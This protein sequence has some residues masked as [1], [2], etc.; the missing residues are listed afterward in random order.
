MSD[1]LVGEWIVIKFS[2][3]HHP[4]Q[5]HIKQFKNDVEEIFVTH[6]FRT[7]DN[8]CVLKS[9]HGLNFSIAHGGLPALKLPFKGLHSILFACGFLMHLVN[10]TERAFAQ[11]L[12][13]L[14][15]ICD[16]CPI[17]LW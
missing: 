17:L 1:L 12:Q 15:S 11:E 4:V 13:D 2:H 6:H 16:D 5:I 9:D 7:R 14:E 3:L 8:I 10:D